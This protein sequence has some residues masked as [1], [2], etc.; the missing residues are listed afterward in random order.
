[1][2]DYI[3]L[4]PDLITINRSDRQRTVIVVDDL[5][6]SISRI[7]QLQP[8]IITRDH[9]LI[10]GERRLQACTELNIP[11]HARYFDT[12]SSLEASIIELEENLRRSELAWQDE[13]KA[14]AK[15]HSLYCQLN[16][17]WNQIKTASAIGCTEFLISRA[18]QVH[19]KLDLPDIASAPSLVNAYNQ[20]LRTSSRK[21]DKIFT[22]L[23]E[24]SSKAFQD[25]IKPKADG[26][27]PQEEAPKSTGP[28]LTYSS[29]VENVSFL[30]WAPAYSGPKF[31]F[32]HCDFPYGKN[33]FRAGKFLGPNSN[34]QETYDDSPDIYWNLLT[35]LGNNLD[36][37]LSKNAHVMFWFA[38]THYQ[39]TLELLESF[40]LTVLPYP[41]LWLKSDNSGVAPDPRRGPRQIYETSFL[42]WRGDRPICKVVS[43]GYAGPIDNSIHPSAKPA[44]M[45]THFFTMLVDETTRMLDPTAGSGTALRAALD[46]KAEFVQGLE[47]DPMHAS[48]AND[49]LRKA[50]IM[51]ALS[52]RT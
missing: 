21:A 35:C 50:H 24:D 41:L 15:I 14:L 25:V 28:D 20:I 37:L 13:V 9:V 3:S 33:V 40:G 51:R 45:L 16:S 30:E 46:L 1:M 47:L 26:P 12:L 5:K 32:L 11:V 6:E 22:Q 38:M 4:S 52:A 17:D 18:L 43:N 34:T 8:I 7:G 10:A 27:S 39:Q 2:P 23:L 48:N 49:Q 19:E 31:N 42:C 44:P 29:L 36:R